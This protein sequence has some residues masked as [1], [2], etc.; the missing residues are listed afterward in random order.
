[1]EDPLSLSR[2]NFTLVISTS[3][4]F[5]LNSDIV[6]FEPLLDGLEAVNNSIILLFLFFFTLK[7]FSER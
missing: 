1:M 7:L 2:S 3:F 5:F 6:V 4:F